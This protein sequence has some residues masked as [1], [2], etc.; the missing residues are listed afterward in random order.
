MH[1]EDLAVQETMVRRFEGL[2]ELARTRSPQNLDFF[3]FALGYARRHLEV[4]ATFGRF[5]HRNP[6][7]GRLS[8]AE[9]SKFLERD[10]A[11][12]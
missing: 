3:Q 10:D 11:G 5:P 2:V 4:I 1:A 7:L 6:I 8:T 12:F 9:E